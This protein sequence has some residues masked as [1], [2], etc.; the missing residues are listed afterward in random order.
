MTV[1]LSSSEYQLL[2]NAFTLLI[3]L[4]LDTDLR[5]LNKTGSILHVFL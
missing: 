3:Y 5:Q 1:F 4:Y 2:T